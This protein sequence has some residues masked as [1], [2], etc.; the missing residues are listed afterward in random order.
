MTK[1]M[2]LQK[3]TFI[4]WMKFDFDNIESLDES[5]FHIFTIYNEGINQVLNLYA[6]GNPISAFQFDEN[7]ET[8]F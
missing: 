7:P 2:L 8:I 6:S 4:D 1:M 3:M 5:W